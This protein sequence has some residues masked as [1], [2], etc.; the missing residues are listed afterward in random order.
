VL[1]EMFNSVQMGDAS[2]ENI[3]MA[4]AKRRLTPSMRAHTDHVVEVAQKLYPKATPF[5]IFSLATAMRQRLN[6]YTQAELKTK[7]GGAPAY[8]YRFEWKSPVCDGRA[9]SF[10]TSELPFC[11]ENVEQC[12]KLVGDGPELHPLAN[13]VAGAW[14]AFAKSGSPNHSGIPRW[15][16]YNDKFLTMVFDK[17]C[18]LKNDPDGDLRKAILESEG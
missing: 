15:E 8:L 12:Y 1:N 5:E 2:L 9:R 14:A 16:P 7:Q 6:A 13:R 4:E 3:D 17:E 11:F 18:A 10:H